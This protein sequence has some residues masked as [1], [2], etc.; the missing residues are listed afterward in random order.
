MRVRFSQR[1]ERIRGSGNKLVANEASESGFGE[2]AGN[3]RIVKLLAI[4]EF[5]SSWDARGVK[6]REVLDIVADGRDHITLH[7]LHVVDVVQELEA[8][9]ANLLAQGRSPGRVVALIVGVVDLGIEQFHHQ[10]DIVFFGERN[11][12]LDS[13]SAVVHSFSVG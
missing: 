2:C 10:D 7:H 13:S 9:V 3:C 11:D 1:A 8:G 6:V 12:L 5:I 4:I